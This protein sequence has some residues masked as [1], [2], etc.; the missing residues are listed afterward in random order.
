MGPSNTCN[1]AGAAILALA[2]AFHPAPAAA[3]VCQYQNLMPEFF[4]FEATTKNLAP[5][6]RAERF[7][8]EFAAKHPGFYGD[9]DLDC[10]A[11]VQ[12]DALRLLFPAN[13][14]PFRAFPR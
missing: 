8:K 9:A 11:R 14:N 3:G 2:L 4:A 5:D 12:K 13:R 1:W 6:I 10:P 7:A